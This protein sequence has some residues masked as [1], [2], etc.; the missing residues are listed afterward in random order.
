M[1]Y[2]EKWQ[3]FYNNGE[4]IVGKWRSAELDNPKPG[5]KEIVG[6]AVIHL[7]RKNKEGKF[8]VLWQRRSE[9][10]D[11]FPG[12]WDVS[13]GGHVNLD[14]TFA[15]AAVREGHEEIG[16]EITK[17]DLILVAFRRNRNIMN[18]VYL[19]DW[20]GREDEFRFDDGEVSEVKWVLLE[21][22]DEFR[23]TNAKAP[24]AEDE[25]TYILIRKWLEYY[26]DL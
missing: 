12:K 18:L 1:H 22:M 6:G 21:E 26:G 11:N 9:K 19:V 4:P 7:F 14:E 23:K 16:I 17:D 20:T 25:A 5:E 13:A 3:L 8:E 10:L 15:D 24:V 2:D